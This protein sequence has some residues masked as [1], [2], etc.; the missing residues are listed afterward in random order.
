MTEAA[1]TPLAEL[2][3][4]FKG[5]RV[6]LAHDWLTGMRGGEKTLEALSEL[7]PQ[8]TLFTMLHVKGSVSPAL[9][10]LNPRTSFVQAM[11]GLA[12]FYRY[13]LPLFPAAVERFDFDEFDLV[14]STSHC[15]TKSVITPGHVPHICYCF[16]PMRYAWDQFDAYFGEARLGARSRLA[17]FAL[18]KLAAWDLATANRPN[19]YVA[20]SQ[21][22]ANRIR[23]Y[24]NR[25]SV[26]VYPPVDT[27]FYHPDRTPAEPYFLVVSALVPYKR[28]DV[29]IEACR[30]VGVP[31]KIIGRGPERGR[32]ERL[33]GSSAEFLGALPDEEVREWYRRAAAVLLPGEE[34]FGIVPVEAQACGRPVVALRKGGALETVIDGVTG[35]LVAEATPEA[36]AEGL[37]AVTRLDVDPLVIRANAERFAR[38]R[39]QEQMAD[40]LMAA[41]ASPPDEVHA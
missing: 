29:A 20:I 32:L 11:P 1:P 35:V 34:D 6:A 17:R 13:A 28:V 38:E 30:R 16:T 10:R 24:Y 7:F 27:R 19:R 22:V 36:F 12:R 23:R 3:D 21:Y 39:F 9:E 18:G 40:L 2:R 37:H 5:V 4:R 33:A 41:L 25:G 14:V 26:I 8:A 15:A 31:L